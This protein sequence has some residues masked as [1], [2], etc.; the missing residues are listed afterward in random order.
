MNILGIHTGHNA[1]AALILNNKLEA[2]IS[3]EK[4]TNIKNYTGFPLNAVNYIMKEYDLTPDNIDFCALACYL[5]ST[6]LPT[7]ER[8]EK[9][10]KGG[11]SPP[12]GDYYLGAAWIISRYFGFAAPTLE[13]F[14]GFY[15][16]NIKRGSNQK[17]MINLLN[18]LFGFRE[19]QINLII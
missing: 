19:S 11:I 8:M 14:Y 15:Q 16:N 9:M 7:Q 17:A 12:L 10:K 1:T 5:N 13:G 18:K 3:E 6:E 4:F 2:A